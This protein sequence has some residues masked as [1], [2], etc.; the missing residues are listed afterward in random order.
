MVTRAFVLIETSTGKSREV[1]KALRRLPL[2]KSADVVT[3]L[4]D[5]IL[6]AEGETLS[7]IGDLINGKIHPIQGITRTMTCLTI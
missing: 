6:V 1:I 5:I 7:D 2:A 4:Y 3:G